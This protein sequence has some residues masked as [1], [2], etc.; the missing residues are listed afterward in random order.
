MGQLLVKLKMIKKIKLIKKYSSEDTYNIM[1][2]TTLSTPELSKFG[3]GILYS[4]YFIYYTL[5]SLLGNLKEVNK[6]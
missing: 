2:H 3:Q 6:K 4:F 5:Q 1:S